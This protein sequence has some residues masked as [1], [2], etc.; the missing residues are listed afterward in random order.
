MKLFLGNSPIILHAVL[1]V[2]STRLIDG[3]NFCEESSTNSILSFRI[4]GGSRVESGL[5]WMAKLISYNENGEGILCGATVIDDFWLMTAAHCARQLKTR[6]YVTLRR[7]ETLKE[8]TFAVQEAYIHPDYNNETADND[9]ALLK[10]SLNLTKRGIPAVCLARND[11][12][13]LKKYNSGMVVGYGLVL[14][15]TS[16]G[17]AILENSQTLQITTVPLIPDSECYTTW[18]VLSLRSVDITKKQLCAGSYMHGTAPGDSGG[19]LLIRKTSGEYVQIGITSFGADGLDGIVDQ[20]KFPGVYT[21]VSKYVPWMERVI[22]S[23]EKRF[24]NSSHNSLLSHF[25]SIF[26]I[27]Q[28]VFTYL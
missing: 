3:L 15:V 26:V 23:R 20:G 27:F 13:F 21:R 9:I 10:I 11:V 24:Q 7:P 1:F 12:D 28:T 8:A 17:S 25:W 6:S 2:Y 14:D 22:Y 18:R 5:N 16:L 19:P 4:I